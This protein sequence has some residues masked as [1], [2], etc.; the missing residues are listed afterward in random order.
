M[1]HFVKKMKQSHKQ[2]HLNRCN[3][4][5]LVD[6]VAGT[7]VEC[8]ADIEE[9]SA[10]TVGDDVVAVSLCYVEDNEYS[11]E[12]LLYSFDEFLDEFYYD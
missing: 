1:M 10:V 6:D 11:I 3:K 9:L 4:S 12:L 7:V 2:L 5:K 8:Y